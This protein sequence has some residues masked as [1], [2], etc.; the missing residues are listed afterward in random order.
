M[1]ARANLEHPGGVVLVASHVVN[2]RWVGV[3]L[4]RFAQPVVVVPVVQPDIIIAVDHDGTSISVEL[5]VALH[6]PMPRQVVPEADEYTFTELSL[7]DRCSPGCLPV[8]QLMH[9]APGHTAVAALA[10]ASPVELV[11]YVFAFAHEARRLPYR[12]AMICLSAELSLV[13]RDLRNSLMLQYFKN[14]WLVP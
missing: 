7:K 11:Q 3:W 10:R 2:L 5:F 13:G 9:T 4:I 1:S 8:A 6:P 12:L 14:T